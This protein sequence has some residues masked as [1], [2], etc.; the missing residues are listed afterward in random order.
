MEYDL[1]FKNIN[2]KI[3]IIVNPNYNFNQFIN[4]L[5]KRLEKLYIK[6]DLLKANAILDIRNIN[7]T[8]KEILTIFDVFASSENILLDK[9]IY[10]EKENK[11][12]ILHEGNIRG[13]EIKLFSSNTLL[14]GNINKGSKVIANGNLYVIGKVSGEVEFKDV[15]SKLYASSIE[16]PYIKIC[17][18]EKQYED[19]LENS[20]VSLKYDQIIEEKF[21]DRRE[22]INGKSNCSYIW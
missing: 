12:I 10:K 6:D 21:M 13:G 18:I 4:S 16:N 1:L 22:R 5:K 20:V 9:I 3:N 11:N 19:I 14:I 2:G 15:N 8:T 7:L 17:S